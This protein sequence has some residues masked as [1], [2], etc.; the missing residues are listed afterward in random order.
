[1]CGGGSLVLGVPRAWSSVATA[2]GGLGAKTRIRAWKLLGLVL[3]V[4]YA[5]AGR[6]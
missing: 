6:E 3:N 1:M 5:S 2:M 4:V